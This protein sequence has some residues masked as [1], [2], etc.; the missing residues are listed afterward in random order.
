M[1]NIILETRSLTK[2]FRGQQEP[3]LDKGMSEKHRRTDRDAAHLRESDGKGEPARPH[4]CSG[5]AG[6]QDRG[7]A[8]DR[9]TSRYGEKE[10]GTLY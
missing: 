2:S 10:S 3:A 4:H 8:E 7:S 1:E 6:R 9:R 5:T